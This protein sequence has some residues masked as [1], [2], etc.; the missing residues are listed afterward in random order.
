[1]KFSIKILTLTII[2]LIAIIGCS[3]NTQ[4]TNNN[5]EPNENVSQLRKPPNL[6][7]VVGEETINPVL[8]SHSWTFEHSDGTTE[9]IEADSYSPSI[10]VEMR[11]PQKVDAN[12][13][14]SFEFETTPKTYQAREWDTEHN[15]LGS[16]NELDLSIHEGKK[17]FEILASWEQGTASYVFY[18]DIE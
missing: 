13:D 7:M 17:I 10:I 11:E 4:E 15:V 5:N 9:S 2:G 12:T 14:I 1:M 18:L 16:N 8:G 3:D 6:Y